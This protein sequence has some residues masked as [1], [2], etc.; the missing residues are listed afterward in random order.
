M[1]IIREMEIMAC[2]VSSLPGEKMF[3]VANGEDICYV[4]VIGE[5]ILL[6]GSFICECL[7]ITYTRTC[8]NK[9]VNKQIN[10]QNLFSSLVQFKFSHDFYYFPVLV[11]LDLKPTRSSS[12]Y[13]TML[14]N[15]FQ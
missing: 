7:V 6:F 13:L 14:K 8:V 11:S 1:S 3:S 5:C 4:D 15:H 9:E 10:L 2:E 12:E